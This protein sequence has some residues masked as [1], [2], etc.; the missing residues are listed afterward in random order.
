[1]DSM[2]YVVKGA[3]PQEFDGVGTESSPN[4]FSWQIAQGKEEKKD[5]PVVTPQTKLRQAESLRRLRSIFKSQPII[6]DESHITKLSECLDESKGTMPKYLARKIRKEKHP[7]ANRP[8]NLAKALIRSEISNEVGPTLRRLVHKRKPQKRRKQMEEEN[9]INM[10]SR[11]QDP[12]AKDNDQAE[13]TKGKLIPKPVYREKFKENSIFVD[14]FSPNKVQSDWPWPKHSHRDPHKDHGKH[15]KLHGS[16]SSASFLSRTV[17][18]QDVNVSEQKNAQNLEEIAFLGRDVS[19]VTLHQNKIVLPEL[20]A[21]PPYTPHACSYLCRNDNFDSGVIHTTNEVS[22]RQNDETE[23]LEKEASQLLAVINGMHNSTWT[24]SHTCKIKNINDL[25]SELSQYDLCFE[26]LA[27][28]MQHFPQTREIIEKARNM[29]KKAIAETLFA[30]FQQKEYW[31][32]KYSQNMALSKRQYERMKRE[33]YNK[34]KARNLLR[35]QLAESLETIHQ[36]RM[37]NARRHM[38]SGEYVHVCKVGMLILQDHESNHMKLSSQ[39]YEEVQELITVA[40]LKWEETEEKRQEKLKKIEPM[41]HCTEKNKVGQTVLDN[42]MPILCDQECS[43]ILPRD[44]TAEGETNPGFPACMQFLPQNLQSALYDPLGSEKSVQDVVD[45]H[46]IERLLNKIGL[47]VSFLLPRKLDIGNVAT[48]AEEENSQE[49]NWIPRLITRK[50]EPDG[51][52]LLQRELKKVI[53]PLEEQIQQLTF[54]GNEREKKIAR[55]KESMKKLEHDLVE[56]N[57]EKKS[58]SNALKKINTLLSISKAENE[59][60]RP[61]LE[62]HDKKLVE[63]YKSLSMTREMQSDQFGNDEMSQYINSL[64]TDLETLMQKTST[65][66]KNIEPKPRSEE[67]IRSELDIAMQSKPLVRTTDHSTSTTEDQDNIDGIEYQWKRNDLPIDGAT[68]KIYALQKEDV[69]QKISVAM[70]YTT[71]S[72]D[73][74]GSVKSIPTGDI[75]PAQ[76]VFR[77]L[78]ADSNSGVNLKNM[79]SSDNEVANLLQ[80]KLKDITNEISQARD[81]IKSL[82]KDEAKNISIIQS[83]EAKIDE[84]NLKHAEITSELKKCAQTDCTKEAAFQDATHLMQIDGVAQEGHVLAANIAEFALEAF[85]DIHQTVTTKK[86]E[87]I[88]DERKHIRKVPK[89]PPREACTP[90][91]HMNETPRILRAE[92]DKNR[93]APY[94]RVQRSKEMQGVKTVGEGKAK[95]LLASFAEHTGLF[96]QFSED[97]M[98]SMMHYMDVINFKKGDWLIKQGEEASWTGFILQGTVDVHVE[99]PGVVAQMHQGEIMGE[100]AYLSGAKRS[101]SCIGATDG[102]MAAIPFDKLDNIHEEDPELS[103]KLQRALALASMEKIEEN[104]KRQVAKLTEE[105]VKTNDNVMEEKMPIIKNSQDNGGKRKEKRKT[106]W[107]KA[108]KKIVGRGIIKRDKKEFMGSSNTEIFYRNMVAQ[109]KKTAKE[110]EEEATK[111]KEKTD[112]QKQKLRMEEVLR[113]GQD[114]KMKKME[115]EIAALKAELERRLLDEEKEEVLDNV[116]QKSGASIKYEKTSSNIL[117][118]FRKK[119]KGVILARRLG[120]D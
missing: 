107:T 62:Y 63:V 117:E 22:A 52:A 9:P 65:L 3:C 13:M 67:H 106:G 24:E 113:K 4:Y 29:Y 43:H 61:K 54:D 2:E 84:L 103:M 37:E 36:M 45:M 39:Q 10:I 70:S 94:D 105:P 72:G 17:F 14:H 35:M 110:M 8:H 120:D 78:S 86:S 85:A 69:G 90:T 28:S 108:R 81:K 20:F 116:N 68:K 12:P 75:Q 99:G 101:A 31:E 53:G 42:S 93:V 58:N 56:A 51:Q 40:K 7:K 34:R 109:H 55:D 11:S 6:T 83:L 21:S 102:I 88:W 87:N 74:R 26:T 76:T 33:E 100:M 82:K 32:R 15:Q 19:A 64:T 97:N 79:S 27:T 95:D 1:M 115:D 111:L 66:L 114:K 96:D 47:Q 73:K 44:E 18:R 92:N 49:S 60:I 50:G 71:P 46:M 38:T 119:T 89:I 41:E 25:K 118:K 98:D 91:K 59:A 30:A 112:K 77:A 16:K 48:T 23:Q 57:K 5:R 80:Q 104:H